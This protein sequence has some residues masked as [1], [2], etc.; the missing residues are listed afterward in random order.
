VHSIVSLHYT[1]NHTYLYNMF[2]YL[3]HIDIY[4][5]T[6]NRYSNLNMDVYKMSVPLY[7]QKDNVEILSYLRLN[8]EVTVY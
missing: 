6:H 3:Q 8:S 5:Y 2:Y 4:I 1:L 7:T